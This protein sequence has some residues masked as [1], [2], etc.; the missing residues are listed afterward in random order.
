MPEISLEVEYMMELLESSWLTGEG[1]DKYFGIFSQLLL[2]I[3]IINHHYYY[4]LEGGYYL[5][6]LY[7]SLSLIQSQPEDVPPNGLTNQARESLKEWSRR[8]SNETIN[9]KDNQLPQVRYT[10]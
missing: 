6:S 2:F 8:R 9:Q 10:G 5:T 7:A 1:M 4:C 3:F